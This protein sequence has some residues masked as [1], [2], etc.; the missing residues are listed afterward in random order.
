M[1]SGKILRQ[2]YKI[3]QSLGRGGFGDTYLAEDLDL[4]GKPKCVVKHL[5]PKSSDPGTLTIAQRLFETEAETLYKLGKDSDQIPKLFAHFQEAT[6]FYL[7]QEYIEGQDIS[8]ELTS[9]K[10]LSESYTITLLKGILEA[11]EKAHQNNIIHRDIKPQNLMRRRSDKK[12]VLI[13]F[14]AVKEITVLTTNQPGTT[15][16]TV[17]VG[18]PGYMPSEQSNGR[19]KLSSDIYAVGMVG[20]KALTGKDPQNLPTDPKTGN[21]IWRNQAKVSNYLANIL[22]RM[23]QEYFPQ[24]YE[25]ATEVL[26]ALS[27]L[28]LAKTTVKVN[29]PTPTQTSTAKVNLLTPTL[30]PKQATTVPSP[31]QTQPNKTRRKILILGGLAGS[32]FAAAML[33]KDWWNQP[34]P[35]IIPTPEPK[36]APQPKT[37]IQKFTTLTV[38]S[39]GQIISRRQ[40][41][42]EVIIENL[43]NGVTLE[44][45][46]I[47]AGTFLMGSPETEAKRFENEDPQH[48][49]DVPEFFMG[50]YPVTQGQW[51]AVMGNNPSWFKGARR[52]VESL[53]WY[54]ATEF[55]QKLSHWTGKKYSLPS[56]SQWEYGVRAGTTTPFYF[57]ETITSELVNFNGNYTYADAPKGKYRKKTTDV[58]IFPPNAFG[59]YDMH[60]NV[61]EWCQDVWHDNYEG[62]PTDGSAWENGGDSNYRLLRGGS[63]SSDSRYCRSGRR[64][65]NYGDSFIF[66]RGFRVVW[67]VSVVSPF[68]S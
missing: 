60:G 19:P 30:A 25:N 38:N 40:H 37:S 28:V 39:R 64:G 12:I 34:S 3:I 36:P 33:S 47:P 11:L 44:M 52:P 29:P 35:E 1:Q 23:V 16:L 54:D 20:I 42:V 21:V 59:L 43:G 49:V 68:R 18:T 58:G 65:S 56:E 50:K 32:G 45:V 61:W 24:R 22:D 14:G 6:E 67:S 15:I 2:R 63:W 26:E 17:A 46:K 13:D 55:C 5:K 8:K 66:Y 31:P 9:G 7:V 48:Y 57:G 62:A 51:Q 27:E 41:Q 53:T 4:P 10:K